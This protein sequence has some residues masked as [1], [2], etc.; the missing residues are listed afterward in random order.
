MDDS[1][2]AIYTARAKAMGIIEAKNPNVVHEIENL[3]SVSVEEFNADVDRKLGRVVQNEESFFDEI[4][5]YPDIKKLILRCIKS[6]DRDR[7]P[8]H[9]ILDGPPA[10]AKSMF[11]LQMQKKL[12]NAYYVDCTNATGAGIVN[13]CL[14]TM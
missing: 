3:A 2:A 11:L 14:N 9:V 8:V 10:S 7:E 5:G 4:V 13:I 12:K 6:S 1:A